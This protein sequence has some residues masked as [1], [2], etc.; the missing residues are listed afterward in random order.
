MSKIIFKIERHYGNKDLK[1]IVEKL[2]SVKL[3]N[4]KFNSQAYDKSYD[5]KDPG[6]KAIHQ[7]AGNK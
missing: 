6:K 1:A 4:L 5:N 7:G 2:L 3:S